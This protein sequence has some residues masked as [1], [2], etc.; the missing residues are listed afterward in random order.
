MTQKYFGHLTREDGTH[1]PLSQSEAEELI[2]Q[3]DEEKEARATA[4]P[5]EA[6]AI[7]AMF[8]AYQR[9]KELGWRD[10]IYCPKDGT[11][12][13]VIENGSTGIFDCTYSGTW[14]DGHFMICDG[15][16]IYP[17]SIGPALFKVDDGKRA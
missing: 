11:P 3:C 4:M 1:V 8:S 7:S 13:K 17:S 10:V 16:D 2:R 9:L 12:F 14:P 6:S 5:D 15:N